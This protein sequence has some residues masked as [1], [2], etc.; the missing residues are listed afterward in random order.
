[1]YIF[2]LNVGFSVTTHITSGNKPEGLVS[3]AKEEAGSM[4]KPS[5]YLKLHT[6]V[7]VDG[8]I[9]PRNGPVWTR[10]RYGPVITGP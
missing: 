6:Q 8:P 10:A 5:N 7:K 3:I 9:R 4:P 2:T 1:M